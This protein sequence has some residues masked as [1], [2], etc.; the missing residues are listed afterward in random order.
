VPDWRTYQSHILS[1]PTSP[2]FASGTKKA[3]IKVDL[4][5]K[6]LEIAGI[7]IDTISVC[8]EQLKDKTFHIGEDLKSTMATTER[9]WNDVCGNPGPIS[10][11]DRYVNGD[12]AAFAYMQSLS[13]GCVAI[14]WQ[15][16]SKLPEHERRQYHE[17]STSE[18]LVHSAAFLSRVGGG[19]GLVYQD[20]EAIATKTQSGPHSWSRAA[21]GAS[22]NR[23]FARTGQGFYVLGPAVME[24]G[25]IICVL[26]GAKMPFCLRPW[27]GKYLLVGECYV[28]GL[29]TG[30][31]IEMARSGEVMERTFLL[32]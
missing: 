18:W 8:S 15:E 24:E 14:W 20:L 11:E 10:L 9:L 4:Q 7:E 2:H 21:N 28:H 26:F 32:V 19:T 1:E 23:A 22:T 27:L 17:V 30:R 6:V 31:A 5:T 16:Q 29:M 13:N 3:R 25:D 12:S